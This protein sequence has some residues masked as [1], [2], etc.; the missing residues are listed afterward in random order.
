MICTPMATR[1]ARCSFI[2]QRS[3]ASTT[4]E[5]KIDR[6]YTYCKQYMRPMKGPHRSMNQTVKKKTVGSA[7]QRRSAGHLLEVDKMTENVS[8]K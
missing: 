6:A 1:S 3:R 2:T 5:C 8:E 4:T 7:I